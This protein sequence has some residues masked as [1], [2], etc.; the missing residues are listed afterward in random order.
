[1][2]YIK[3][4][5]KTMFKTLFFM[6]LITFIGIGVFTFCKYYPIYQEYSIESKEL[7]ANSSYDTFILN[8]TSYIYDDNGE[9]LAKLK[10]DTDSNYLQYEKIPKDFI[11]AFIA[12]ED[13]TFWTN[14]GYDIK[15]IARVLYNAIKTKGDELHGASTITQQLARL[16]FLSQEVS[17]ERKVK[18]ILISIELTNKYTKEDIMEFYCNDVYFANGYYGISAAAKG[19]FNKEVDELSLS[20]IAYL[21]SIP[22]RPS[23]YNPYDNVNNA[24]S[25][26]DK[27]LSDMLE[28]NYITEEEYKQAINETIEVTKPTNI[29]Y[30]YQ[31]SYAIDCAIQYLMKKNGFTFC[32]HFDTKEDYTTYNEEYNSAYEE[33]KSELYSGGYKVY[34][35]L[36]DEAQSI[37]QD[38]IDN[39]LSFN[40]ELEE[41]GSFAL[42]GAS[43][44]I[45]NET[46]KVIA[47]VGGRTEENNEYG[48]NR[49]YQSYR[50]PGSTLKPLIVYTP[51]LENS[52]T[53]NSILQNISVSQSNNLFKNNKLSEILNLTG[54]GMTLR[55]AVEYSKNGCAY[56]LFSRVGI[57]VGL[58]KLE[59]MQF[60]KITYQD[61]NIS[62]ALGGLTYG[63]TTVEMCNAY[64]TLVNDGTFV[65][66]TCI[67]SI[68]DRNDNEIYKENESISVYDKEASRKMVDILKGVITNGTAKNMNW[69][70]EMPIAG[71]TG[72][73]N[74]S[75]DGWFCGFSPYY[76][77]AVWVGYDTPKEVNGLYG[78]TY[79][80]TIWKI[81][82]EQLIEDKEIIQFVEPEMTPS[83]GNEK[84]LPGRSDDELLSDGYTVAD[85]RSDYAIVDEVYTIANQILI[86]DD[87]NVINSLYQQGNQKIETIYGRN[88]TAKAR[89]SL[90]SAYNSKLGIVSE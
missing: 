52:Y 23:Y 51:A 65:E 8:E 85:Y 75:K 29:T 34:T 21:C 4:F 53:P 19:Y 78:G 73:T 41:D 79:P 43:T 49:A 10:T 77:I 82:M 30:N 90:N 16:T 67:T 28:E 64:S 1:M 81:T 26:R 84:Y 58:N 66:T 37:L 50:Q 57:D 12:I 54:E 15:G 40:N 9:L 55:K 62:A 69:N 27:I 31:T 36:N 74:N 71:K 76:T 25:R 42:Q 86:T 61:Y 24:I 72:T 17:L 6:S 45:D 35:S 5:L 59:N 14:N 80:S 11:N 44:V 68:L 3:K 20:Q 87:I 2:K 63:T 13:R 70:L 18:E 89:D 60:K 39:T 46:R 47:I 7:V 33:A 88:A 83:T 56:Y 22:N 32:Y 38:T 48:I